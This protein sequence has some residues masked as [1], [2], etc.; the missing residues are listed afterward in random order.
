VAA[1]A[2]MTRAAETFRRPSCRRGLGALASL[3]AL[4]AVVAGRGYALAREAGSGYPLTALIYDVAVFG[5]TLAALRLLD[6]L[7]RAGARRWVGETTCGQRAAGR[8]PHAALMIAVLFPGLLVTLRIHPLR[9]E[10][11]GLPAAVG[12]PDRAV[13]G[14]ATWG[15]WATPASGRS[16]D[17]APA[18]PRRLGRAESVQ[19]T[20]APGTPERPAPRGG[21][22]PRFASAD[23]RSP[24]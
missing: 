20:P 11:A 9:A 24:G 3:G 10:P 12:R 16:R 4:L 8:A 15:R 19:A 13:T 2:I 23:E 17:G 6:R 21:E 22:V 18:G 14:P 1:T 5:T 7:I